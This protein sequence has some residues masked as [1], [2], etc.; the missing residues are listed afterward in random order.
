L[1]EHGEQRPSQLNHLTKQL[2]KQIWKNE[3]LLPRI[4]TFGW[5]L[6]R[7]AMPTGARAGKYSKQVP[8][9][10]RDIV[11]KYKLESRELQTKIYHVK[12]EVNGVAHSCAH[13]A[14]IQTKSAHTFSRSNSAHP[15]GTCT[16]AFSL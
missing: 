12:S 4:Q 3:Q 13:E 15:L 9:E 2:L 5:M 11:A 6:L 7:K 16:V 14:I 8:W 1:Q 10:I